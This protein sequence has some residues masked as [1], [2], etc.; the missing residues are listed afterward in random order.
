MTTEEM[1]RKSTESH[2]RRELENVVNGYMYVYDEYNKTFSRDSA[3]LKDATDALVDAL[4][5]AVSGY[6]SFG[7]AIIN[8]G[9]AMSELSNLQKEQAANA[10]KQ[11]ENFGDLQEAQISGW[12]KGAAW[13]GQ[14][15]GLL[16]AIPTSGLSLLLN[17]GAT[18]D[19]M[20]WDSRQIDANKKILKEN[21]LEEKS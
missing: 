16:L 2:L 17:A 10:E 20:A 19:M 9:I 13:I 18:A 7:N 6:D 8:T 15:A 12:E 21:Y 3:F 11:I 1:C 4:P 14:I 5:R